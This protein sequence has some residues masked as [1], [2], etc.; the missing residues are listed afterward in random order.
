[1]RPWVTGIAGL[2][3]AAVPASDAVPAGGLKPVDVATAYDITPLHDRG[4]D[5]S[6]LTIAIL[7]FAGF[8]PEEIRA[9]DSITGTTGPAPQRVR[10]NGGAGSV[11]D[12]EVA[13]DIE[14]IRG[15]A[16]KAK[17]VSYE[18]PRNSN[19]T[20]MA[21]IIDRV[22]ADGRA[23]ILSNSWGLCDARRLVNGALLLSKADRNRVANSL[24]AAAAAGV[25]MFSASG[26]S[27]AFD[28][29]SH[30]LSDHQVAPDFPASLPNLVAVGGTRL[31]VREDGTYFEETGWEDILTR[32][33]GGG[34][35]S[36][37]DPRPDYQRG[38]PGIDNDLSNGRRQIPDVAATADPD[39]GFL[40]VFRDP[41]SGQ[42]VQAT[43]G[44]T[45]AAAP[46]W[47]G[48]MLL[49]GQFARARGIDRVGFAAPLLYRIA[50][51]EDPEAPAFHDVVLG[52]D[53]LHDATPGWDYSTG[54]GSPD[55]FN[56]AR[57]VVA[58]L[59]A[60]G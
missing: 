26:D 34:G 20:A 1:M 6:G 54:L 14:V 37:L 60:G 51:H 41:R 16:P 38:V 2:N 30:L 5:G 56:L 58:R 13:L 15:I 35:L 23:D 21:T 48:S 33:G 44:G 10:V 24:A 17:I 32:S 4:F 22:V 53:R 28:C 52:G 50:A 57:A 3:G 8:N 25:T 7:S 12:A 19:I 46:F 27:G 47:A 49:V 29:Q 39:S 36:P 40:T 9:W 11:T 45:S 55:V 43:I 59:G 42:M 18:A 31:S